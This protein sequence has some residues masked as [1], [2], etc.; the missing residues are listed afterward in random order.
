MFTRKLRTFLLGALFL[1][2]LP[3][4]AFGLNGCRD[5][6]QYNQI[7]AVALQEAAALIATHPVRDAGVQSPEAAK[8][9]CSRLPDPGRAELLPF[10]TD[11]GPMANVL[12]RPEGVTDPAAV[13]VSHFDTKPG[14]PDFVGANDGAGTTGLLIA[15]ARHTDLPV[16]YLFLD[17]EECLVSYTGSDGLHGSWHTARAGNIPKEL[18][19]L[20]LDMLGDR[21][22]TPEL[23]ANGSPWLNAL[24]LRAADASS[25]PLQ[26]TGDMIDDH[27][28]FVAHGYRAANV[29]DFDFGPGHAWWHTPEDTLDKLSADSLA[30]TARFVQAAVHLLEKENP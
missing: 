13:L 7:G 25:Y 29:I 9:I 18:P 21:D 16:W 6:A 20:V 2:G 3:G 12:Y 27:I 1:G 14:I 24:L 22:L 8:W 15:L 17:G 26:Q 28:P 5:A 19:I 23:A 4:G 10:S 30:A 11:R